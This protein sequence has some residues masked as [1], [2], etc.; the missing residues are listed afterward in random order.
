MEA[1]LTRLAAQAAADIL[2]LQS[3]IDTVTQT[4]VRLAYRNLLRA[5]HP[6]TG[7]TSNAA[8]AISTLQ[9][10]RDTLLRWVA[11]RPDPRC[12][13]CGGSGFIKGVM[14]SHVACPRCA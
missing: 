8:D 9:A 11:E 12:T 2:E 6:D 7:M 3:S 4:E 14:F 13:F 10:S 5:A 1:T